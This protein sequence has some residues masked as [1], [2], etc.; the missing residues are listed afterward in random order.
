M[1]LPNIPHWLPA[2]ACVAFLIGLAL[3]GGAL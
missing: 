2:A 1:N 3:M